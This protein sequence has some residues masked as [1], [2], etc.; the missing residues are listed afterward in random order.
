MRVPVSSLFLSAGLCRFGIPSLLVIS[1]RVVLFLGDRVSA[2]TIPR[3]IRALH[4]QAEEEEKIRKR[5]MYIY[6]HISLSLYG[7]VYAET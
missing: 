5:N 2:V 1:A 3:A 4:S 6:H 7:D